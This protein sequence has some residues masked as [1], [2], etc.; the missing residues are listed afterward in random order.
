MTVVRIKYSLNEN[1]SK[2]ESH[3]LRGKPTT[4]TEKVDKQ[5]VM[6]VKHV[7]IRDEEGEEIIIQCTVVNNAVNIELLHV[8]RRVV[9]RSS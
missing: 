8:I 5:E 4:T 2:I 9:Y 1:F 3:L 6:P 7:N